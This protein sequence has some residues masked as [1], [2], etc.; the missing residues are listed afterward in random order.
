M[1]AEKRNTL[2][3]SAGAMICLLAPRHPALASIPFEFGLAREK[4]L[5]RLKSFKKSGV[6]PIID[7]ESSY[8][9][10]RI[11]VNGFI[12]AMDRAGIA[13]MCLSA[14]QPGDLIKNGEIWSHNS[15][16]LYKKF[17]SHFIPTGNGAVHPVWPQY[18]DQFLTE[19]ERYL[20]AHRYPLMGEFEV[21]HYPSPRQLERGEDRDVDIPID[22]AEMHR[23]F[24]LSETLGIPFQLHYEIEDRLLNPLEKMLLQYPKSKVIWCHLAQIRYQTR[25]KNYT[26]DFVESLISKYPNIYFDLAFGD[27]RSVYKSSGERHARYW[28]SQAQWNQL[29]EKYPTRFLA[30]LDIGGDRMNRIE[31][32]SLTLRQVLNSISMPARE[33]VAYKSAWKL[34]FNE[35]I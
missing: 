28:S 18:S 3:K 9:P 16:E 32:W 6:L 22:G 30:A 2:R 31:E 5:A 19:S 24:K 7:I 15:L 1:H 29:I 17:P 27:S 10:K 20:S 13:L 34:L 26:P 23:V 14:N 12:S 25:S 11:D 35:D 4:Y 33:L 8:N 21:R